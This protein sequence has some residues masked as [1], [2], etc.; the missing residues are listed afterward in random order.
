[1]NTKWINNVGY[2]NLTTDV[3]TKAYVDTMAS[4]GIAYHQPVNVATTTTLAVATNGGT[5]YVS[6]NGAANGIGAYISTTGTF[7]N[8]DGVNVQTVGTRI[9][10]KNEVNST[11]NGV[12]TYANTTAIVRSTDADEYGPD[13]TTQFSINDYFFTQSG[14]VNTGIAFIVGAPTGPITF[15]TSNI[16]FSVF[17]SSL[18]YTGGTGIT[19]A[20]TVVSVNPT[21]TLSTLSVSGDINAGNLTV[22]ETTTF[23]GVNINSVASIN[24]LS[25][26]DSSIFT[27]TVTLNDVLFAKQIV[28][29]ISIIPPSTTSLQLDMS[30]GSIFSFNP[31]GNFTLAGLSNSYTGTSAK[32]IITQPASGGAIMTSSIKFAGGLK[33]LSVTPGAIDIIEIFSGFVSNTTVYYAKLTNGYA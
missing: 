20:G 10:V 32:I 7:S 8:I 5:T 23:S 18:I 21:Q 2:P 25:V 27:G 22:A 16:T 29:T 30:L 3:A 1:M 28:E 12:Y 4:T 24:Q 6:P 9:L 26:D 11:W 19:I 15:G 31:T 33:T 17:N 13:S 14:T